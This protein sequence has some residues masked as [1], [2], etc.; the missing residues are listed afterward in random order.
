MSLPASEL[1]ALRVKY[2]EMRSMRIAH[3][4]GGEEPDES[5]R[6]MASLAA[7]FPGALREIDDLELDEISARI[8]K[9]DSA[10][11]GIHAVE[12]WM[13]AMAL[14]HT[15]ARGAL[16]A[17][18]WLGGRKRVGPDVEQ[19]FAAHVVAT[20]PDDDARHWAGALD[21]LASPPSGRITALVYARIA[22]AIG[23]DIDRARAL[24]F[25]EGRRARAR[26]RQEP[27]P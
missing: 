6:R 24:V 2:I 23:V 1:H 5:R 22:A 13:E 12:P 11:S 16:R 15:L 7:R 17:K 20:E 10:L 26:R 19:S 3:A 9:L 8:E 25:G 27:L 4:S 21:A 14:F 18:R